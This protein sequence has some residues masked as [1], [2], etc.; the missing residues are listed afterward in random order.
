VVLTYDAVTYGVVTYGVVTY[1][2]VAVE[3][4]GRTLK[5]LKFWNDSK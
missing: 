1:G 3:S 2:L 4:S 5:K